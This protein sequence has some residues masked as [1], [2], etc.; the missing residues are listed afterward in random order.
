MWATACAIQIATIATPGLADSG[1]RAPAAPAPITNV[2]GAFWDGQF[3]GGGGMGLG[4]RLSVPVL[5][6]LR[7]GAG[8]ASEP[9]IV[10][11]GLTGGVGGLANLA[12]GGAVEVNHLDGAFLEVG[13]AYGRNDRLLLHAMAGYT[14]FG[15]A[16][17]QLL[18][19][20]RPQHAVLAVLRLPV[21]IWWLLV[22]RDRERDARAARLRRPKRVP[23]PAPEVEGPDGARRARAQ[24]LCDQAAEAL[25]A[26]D[27]AEAERAYAEAVAL[28]DVP[29]ARVALANVRVMRGALVKAAED[30]RAALALAR[31]HWQPQRLHALESRY[32]EV[33]GRLSQLRVVFAEG[34]FDGTVIVDGRPAPRVLLGYDLPL[35]PGPHQLL[36]RRGDAVVLQRRIEAHEGEIIRISV[37]GKP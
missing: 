6:R 15:L 8:Y 24:R 2:E 22:G 23:L 34:S 12:V 29:H 32:L 26:G 33:F 11:A 19:D 35:D 1:G 9:W 14:V 17:E 36:I 7:L 18:A 10:N 3:V 13:A 21:G 20:V 5:A 16:Y 37:P 4:G 30:L 28:V 25:V 27:A 31:D